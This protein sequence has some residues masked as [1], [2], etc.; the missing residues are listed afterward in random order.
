MVYTKDTITIAKNYNLN[1]R[2]V[3][4]C[5]LVA[6][7]ADRGEAFYTIYEHKKNSSI[8]TNEQARTQANEFVRDHPGAAVLIQRLKLR[9]TL[10]TTDAK[11]E[12]QAAQ[13]HAKMDGEIMEEARKFTD[14]SYILAQYVSLLPSLSGKDRADILTK[15]ADLQRMKQEENKEKE[16]VRR[17]YLPFVSHCRTCKLLGIVKDILQDEKTASDGTKNG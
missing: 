14:K 6:S 10:N 16:E 3:L 13:Q 2:D 8:K 11:N 9:K 1:E 7:G 5:T 17:F 4:F 12:A 15:I